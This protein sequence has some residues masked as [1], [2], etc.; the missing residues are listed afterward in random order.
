M[1]I[2]K[3]TKEKKNYTVEGKPLSEKEFAQVIKDSEE[4]GEMDL[5]K[6][7]EIE[8]AKKLLLKPK[9]IVKPSVRGNY[10]K[11]ETTIYHI[12]IANI[13]PYNIWTARYW[14]KS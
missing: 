12:D 14:I 13:A 8:N 2:A 11:N 5:D 6:G 9:F 1:G 4:S 3:K 7:I 10:K